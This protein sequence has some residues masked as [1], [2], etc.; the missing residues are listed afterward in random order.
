MA[1]VADVTVVARV[2]AGVPVW[3]DEAS[4]VAVGVAVGQSI[5]GSCTA[6]LRVTSQASVALAVAPLIERDGDL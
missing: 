2:A 5:A 4:E 3:I 6:D 1:V